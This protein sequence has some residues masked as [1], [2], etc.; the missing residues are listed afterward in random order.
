VVEGGGGVGGGESWGEVCGEWVEGC[1][2]MEGA[3]VF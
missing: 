2:G 3:W 1:V